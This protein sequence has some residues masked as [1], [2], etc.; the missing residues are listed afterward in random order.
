LR[1]IPSGG[2]PR[3]SGNDPSSHN[4]LIGRGFPDTRTQGST[5]ARRG[6]EVCPLRPRPRRP[7]RATFARAPRTSS[8][9]LPLAPG[10]GSHDFCFRRI[11]LRRPRRAP[12]RRLGRHRRGA[13]RTSGGRGKARK[14]ASAPGPCIDALG[15]SAS[16]PTT[17]DLEAHRTLARETNRAPN[18]VGNIAPSTRS[19]RRCRWRVVR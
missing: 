13:K 7:D 2:G 6:G 11:L 12:H 18:I 1:D 5:R 15:V 19:A 9:R 10:A 14:G 3:R 8:G 17:R 16:G 4:E